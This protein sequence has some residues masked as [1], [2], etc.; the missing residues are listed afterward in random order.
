M[1]PRHNY[2]LS[3]EKPKVGYKR[4]DIKSGLK[5]RLID[6]PNRAN[7]ITQRGYE[8]AVSNYSRAVLEYENAIRYLMQSEEFRNLYHTLEN[9]EEVFIISPNFSGGTN[10]RPHSQTINW[11]P[12]R[13]L[14]LVDNS[15]QSAALALVHEMGHAAQY[16]SPYLDFILVAL[17]KTV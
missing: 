4:F 11:N 13:G 10:F 16:L 5:I 2:V 3:M 15:V 1:C 7:H 6:A 14:I 8:S 12:A 9:A 17:I